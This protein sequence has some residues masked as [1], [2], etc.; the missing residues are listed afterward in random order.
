M[1]MRRAVRSS[2]ELVFTSAAL[3]L[4]CAGCT[5]TSTCNR[6]PDEDTVT[7]GKVVVNTYLS[8]PNEGSMDG[9]TYGPF[10]YFPPARTLT[11]E[12]HLGAAPPDIDIWLAFRDKGALAP[13]A[14]NLSILEY[15]DAQ[16]IQIK[17]DTCSEYW[18]R[19]VASLPA[20][21]A[22]LPPQGEAGASGADPSDAA[23]ASSGP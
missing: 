23:G 16:I 8:A 18:V 3:A 10:A 15:V 2:L 22:P 9:P 20:L 19:L 5:F 13:S 6:D 1:N 14:G 4:A 21:P 12:H 11:F 7:T 17:N